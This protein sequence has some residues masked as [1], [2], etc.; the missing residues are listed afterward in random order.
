MRRD[1]LLTASLFALAALAGCA[2]TADRAL[3]PQLSRARDLGAPVL[4][5]ALGVPGQ[6]DTGANLTAVPV[7]IQFVVTSGRSIRR[8]RF[9]LV[10]YSPRGIPVRARNG[11]HMQMQLI[12]PGP[13]RPKGN[14]EVNSFH[15]RPAGFPGGDVACVELTH[16]RVTFAD[17]K[18]ETYSAGQINPTLT[19][20]L[21]HGCNDQGPPVQ[22]MVSDGT[23][24]DR[25]T[26]SP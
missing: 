19:P 17:G 1:I 25:G 8:I 24:L 13:F 12:G 10:G 21:R 22:R 15:S 2:T 4:I 14:Y 3:G 11:A 23:G 26:R 16:M 9:V 6:I 7:Y 5:Y 18:H 20:S